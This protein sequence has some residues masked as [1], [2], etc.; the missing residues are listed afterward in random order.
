MALVPKVSKS[1]NTPLAL[2]QQPSVRVLDVNSRIGPCSPRYFPINIVSGRLLRY[3]ASVGLIRQPGVDLYEANK[4]S[5]NLATPEAAI[6][7]AHLYA[8]IRPL[9]FRIY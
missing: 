6:I 5:Q 9:T 7:S 8:G 4:K 1:F 3:M 2:I